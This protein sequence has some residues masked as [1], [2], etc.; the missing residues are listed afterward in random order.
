MVYRF[1]LARNR[2]ILALPAIVVMAALISGALLVWVHPLLGGAGLVLTAWFGYHFI[3]L[4]AN[5]LQSRIST[6]EDGVVFYTGSG[7]KIELGWEQITHAGHF[8]G[9]DGSSM[10]FVYNDPD[11][12]LLKIPPQF[13]DFDQLE[14]E[15]L[16]YVS[17]PLSLTGSAEG[18]VE[19]AL[20]EIIGVD[21]PIDADNDSDPNQYSD[22]S[23][24]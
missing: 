10:L 12:R 11:D 17:D 24:I 23:S 1:E 15:I 6:T 19:A 5:Q 4:F 13:S 2:R 22:D 8:H 21:E 9:D 7:E 14:A 16:E 18:G 3:K 20:R